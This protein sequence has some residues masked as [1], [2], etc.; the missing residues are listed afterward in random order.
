MFNKS[1]PIKAVFFDLG[2]TL[3]YFS[4]DFHK[5]T[6]ESYFVLADN[7][8]ASGC[9]FDRLSFAREFDKKMQD[10]YHQRQI[11]YFERPV[12]DILLNTL[13]EFG[14]NDLP[15]E[16]TLNA[17][18]AMY[19]TTESCWLIEEDTHETL[20]WLLDHNYS[21]GLIS[22][23]ANAWD[24]N[25]LIDNHHLRKYFSS[26]LISASEGIRKPNPLIFQRA[27]KQVNV[28]LCEAVM[29]GDTLDADI[30]GAHRV[31]MPGIWISRRKEKPQ[32]NGQIST[33]LQ[34]DVEIHTL[35][36]LPPLLTIWNKE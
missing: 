12:Q 16:V 36:E 22:N 20:Q 18:Q 2:Y 13:A 11:D 30:L 32:G 24:V 6:F 14:Q 7:L 19:L 5:S 33:E 21:L 4:G 28:E 9:Q 23:A 31:G 15:E 17:M 29:V 1:R 34:P 27:A 26:I 25:N 35:R 3:I 10:Y 8:V